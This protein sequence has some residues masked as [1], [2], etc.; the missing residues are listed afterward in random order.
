MNGKRLLAGVIAVAAASGMTAG[1][2]LETGLPVPPSQWLFVAGGMLL[3]A[4]GWLI[5][6]RRPANPYGWLVLATALCLG[7]GGLGVG[8]LLHHARTGVDGPGLGVAVAAAALYGVHYG[9]VWIFIPLLFP[10][11]RLPSPRWRP[12]A[13]A[14]GV[15]VAVHTIGV[16]FAPGLLDEDVP[17]PNPLALPGAAGSVAVGA[18]TAG[19]LLTPVIAAGA[20]GALIVRWRGAT[21]AERRQLRWMTAGI[22]LNGAGFLLVLGIEHRLVAPDLSWLALLPVLGAVPAA[23]GVAIVRYNLLDIRVVI[24]RSLAYGLLWS[25]IALVYAGVATA[26]G[27]VAGE[28]LPVS[29]AIVLTVLVT[30]VFQPVRARLEALADRLVYG[31]R[32]TAA[33]VLTQISAALDS[34]TESSGQL[35]HL[36]HVARSALGTQWIAV[37][38]D[39]GTEANA[40][41]V[42]GEPE[43]TVPIRNEGRVVGRL[44]CGPKIE[45]KLTER[46]HTLLTALAAQA[47]LALRGTRLAARLVHAQETE[48]RRIERNIHDGVQQQL[49]AL[50]AGLEL[51]RAAPRAEALTHLREQ[52][53][54]TLEDLRELAAGI[55][56][57]VLTQGGPGRSGGGAMRPAAHRRR[58]QRRRRAARAALSRR[59]RGRGLLHDRR[60]PRQHAEARRRL[61][62]RDTAGATRRPSAGR[63]VR[64]RRGVRPRGCDPSRARAAGRPAQRARRQPR[65]GQRSKEG[66]QGERLDTGRWLILCGRYSPTTTTSSGRGSGSCWR[67]PARSA[68][69]RRSATPT[70]S[71]TRSAGS[72]LT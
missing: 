16:L 47:G 62:G 35:R 27:V 28:R 69:S 61:T 11:G 37:R 4:L 7:V 38:L 21:P 5:A 15:C 60:G 2:V 33:Q 9:L 31:V 43:W 29:V 25:A 26:L 64:R 50:I 71:S 55:H 58:V 67:P 68:S 72:S 22:L 13:W 34:M 23:I 56:P 19:T 63:G 53:R 12:L 17:V 30:L 14:G 20:I 48:R 59:H 46:D 32:P 42:T 70:S 40:G 45:G 51:A 36:A 8:T 18:V 3:P 6:S 52:A 39:D 57:T 54:A 24:R 1:A 49:V 44:S 66:D 65:G 10:D 41:A